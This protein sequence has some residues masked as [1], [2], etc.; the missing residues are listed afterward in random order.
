MSLKDGMAAINLEMPERV[1]RTEY[2][3]DGHWELVKRVT[4]IDVR[5]DSPW[6][7]RDRAAREFRRIWNYDFVWNVLVSSQYLAKKR[8]SM[9]HAVYAS[10]GTDFDTHIDCPFK[11]P[12]EVLSFDPRTATAASRTPR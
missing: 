8:T 7:V 1:P 4:G 10:G 5:F 9:G 2:S 12:E 11:T 3:V 6:E